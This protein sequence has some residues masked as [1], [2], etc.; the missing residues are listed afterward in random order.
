MLE[1]V[2]HEFGHILR[3]NRAAAERQDE[4]P[5]ARVSLQV[6]SMPDERYEEY[7][8][9]SDFIREHIFP[10]GHLPCRKSIEDA[11]HW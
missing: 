10:G 7:V 1:A 9:S 2:G 8:A 4:N 3:N 6:I 5:E 11:L